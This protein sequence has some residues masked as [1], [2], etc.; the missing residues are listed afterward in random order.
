MTIK[1]S[2]DIDM[3]KEEFEKSLTMCYNVVWSNKY[4]NKE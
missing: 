3:L 1:E 4:H 2:Y